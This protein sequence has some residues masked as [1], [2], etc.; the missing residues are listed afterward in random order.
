VFIAVVVLI[1]MLIAQE[2]AGRVAA[3]QAASGRAAGTRPAADPGPTGAVVVA[4]IT[5]GQIGDAV[6]GQVLNDAGAQALNLGT[7]PT[8]RPRPGVGH[9]GG[10]PA[11]GWSPSSGP[12]SSSARTPLPPRPCVPGQPVVIHGPG[13]YRRLYPKNAHWLE[14]AGG[15]SLVSWPLSGGGESIGGAGADVGPAA[16][17]EHRP[18]GVYLGGGHVVAQAL[19]VRGSTPTSMLARRCCRRRS[20]RPVRQ[21]LRDSTSG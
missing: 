12:A 6:A 14:V 13:E 18:A 7:G 20:C 21:T 2:A 4:A 19:V 15:A 9:D 16:A 10:I 11:A 8:R 1:S 17:A 3:V 5:P